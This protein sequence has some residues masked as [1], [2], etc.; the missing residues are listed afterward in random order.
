MPDDAPVPPDAREIL[1]VRLDEIGD[2]VMTTG[3][4]RALRRA[5]PEAR[6][7]LV[8]RDA[9]VGLL[10]GCPWVDEVLGHTP[11][12]AGGRLRTLVRA[13]AAWWFAR[14]RL[15]GRRFDL[16]IQPRWDVDE[17]GAHLIIRY[18][19][20]RHRVGYSS[21]VSPEKARA[22]RNHDASFTDLSHAPAGAVH[23][24][25]RSFDLLRM[26]GI[27]VVDE[28]LDLW[29]TEE[30][31]LWADAWIAERLPGPE[32]PVVAVVP[33]AGSPRR[34]WPAARFAAVARA[35]AERPGARIIVLGSP[36]ER[37]LAEEVAL[38]AP[39]AVVAAGE[40]SLRQA[41][42][43]ISRCHVLVGND[44]G[45]SHIAVA[46]GT[47]VV[48]VFCHPLGAPPGVLNAPERFAPWGVAARVVRPAAPRAPCTGACEGAGAHCILEVGIEEVVNAVRAIALAGSQRGGG[49]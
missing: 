46:V 36:E 32:R 23:E 41:A 37:T 21:D 7:T 47:P 24:V 1:V 39:G 35:L 12:R 28:S 17:A 16:A 29:I 45:P 14:T 8:V 31:R 48:A 15:R 9:L 33:G 10:A 5:F 19:R 25:E 20:A 22:H 13:A 34:R 40:L 38:G 44:T 27:A 30:E 26:L 4:L 11:P 2:V 18:S 42:A 43:V 3:L 6:I 49:E